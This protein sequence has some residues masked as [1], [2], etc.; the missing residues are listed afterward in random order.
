MIPTTAALSVDSPQSILQ[1]AT[2]GVPL[3]GGPAVAGRRAGSSA[4]RSS[5]PPSLTLE[6]DADGPGRAHVFAWT[7]TAS[8]ADAVVPLQKGKTTR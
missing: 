7:G 1:S 4:S 5:P 8:V 6:L 3:G 2:D